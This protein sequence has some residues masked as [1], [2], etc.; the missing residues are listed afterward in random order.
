MGQ[1]I[2]RLGEAAVPMTRFGLVPFAR[3]SDAVA[4]ENS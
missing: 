3:E 2:S 4:R 1:Q